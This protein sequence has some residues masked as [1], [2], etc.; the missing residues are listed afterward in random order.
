MVCD[1]E[2][3][4]EH[5]GRIGVGVRLVRHG[6][7]Q[8]APGHAGGATGGEPRSGGGRP[9]LVEGH[10]RPEPPMGD[11]PDPPAAKVFALLVSGR[12]QH[13]LRA[14]AE[15][16]REYLLTGSAPS[17]VD[18]AYSLA[19]ART[20]F[21]TRGAVVGGDRVAL[22]EGLEALS[23]GEPGTGVLE[24]SVGAGKTAF[25]FTGQGAQRAGMGLSLYR[26]F[27]VFADALDTVC[28]DS[29]STSSASHCE[30]C[31]SR[32]RARR[33]GAARRDRV[34]PGEPVCAGGGA[35]PA[36]RDVR[37]QAG[38]ADRPLGRGD[39]WPPTSPGSSRSP[40]PV[41]WCSRGDG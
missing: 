16:L 29:R 22:L 28:A 14:Q 8:C 23:R 33:G 10:E 39:L 34:H 41:R 19:C 11:E 6:R 17:V 15:R 24:G 32:P 26:S 40:T 5:D 7:R 9:V 3:W 35:L 31:C 38:H 2:Q 18:V 13:A 4:P 20:Q 21:E 30:S 27:P 37:R 1:A 36:G 25:M 12:G